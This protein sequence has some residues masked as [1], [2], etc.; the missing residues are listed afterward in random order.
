MKIGFTECTCR[1][2]QRSPCS[3]SRALWLCLLL[4]DITLLWKEVPSYAH[5]ES[6]R[7]NQHSPCPAS[8]AL[9]LCLLLIMQFCVIICTCRVM[10]HSPCPAS[11]ALYYENWCH[12][13]HMHMHMQSHAALTL[14]CLTSSVAVLT[15]V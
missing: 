6:C 8:R 3:A 14:P 12:H 2:M 13:M 5:A 10:Q 11:Q 7:F 1:V 9:W 4:F 15:H